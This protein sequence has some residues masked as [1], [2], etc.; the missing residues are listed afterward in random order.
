MKLTL[1][2]DGPY[3][4]KRLVRPLEPNK[5]VVDR[6]VTGQVEIEYEWI[7]Q[8]PPKPGQKVSRRGPLNGTLRFSLIRAE[9]LLNLNL[10]SRSNPFALLFVYP[11]SPKQDHVG[12]VPPMVW[13]SPTMRE[14]CDPKW[15]VSYTFQY[16]WRAGASLKRQAT[17]LQ[18]KKNRTWDEAMSLLEQWQQDM[19][20]I[21]KCVRSMSD[22]VD[23][24][25][26]C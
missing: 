1:D 22:R 17:S 2:I 10:Q 8:V 21:K 23:V 13:Q 26:S 12:A 18:E 5:G 11:F 9:G 4:K 24:L 16:S 25:S 20:E 19:V 6:P 14:T 3:V 15:L 7:P